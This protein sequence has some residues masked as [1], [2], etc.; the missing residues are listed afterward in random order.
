MDYSACSSNSTA[1][2]G[3]AF[4][5]SSFGSFSE[6][7][8]VADADHRLKH[9]N[10]CAGHPTLARVRGVYRLRFYLVDAAGPNPG[11][12]SPDADHLAILAQRRRADRDSVAIVDIATDKLSACSAPGQLGPFLG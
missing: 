5:P 1:H 6:R 10:R 2:P 4:S 7:A 12:D 9:P 8:S 11:P 3:V